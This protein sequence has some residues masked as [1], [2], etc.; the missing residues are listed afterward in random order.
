MAAAA[1]SWW[2][3]VLGLRRL[4][5]C[6]LQRRCGTWEVVQERMQ[7]VVLI[8]DIWKTKHVLGS[9]FVDGKYG[10]LI[11]RLSRGEVPDRKFDGVSGVLL[12]SDSFNDNGF[13]FCEPHW[14]SVKLH[15]I[16]GAASNLGEEVICHSFLRWL[17]WW[18][19]R[20]VTDVGVKLR[21]VGFYVTC[22]LFFMI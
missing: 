19:R 17:L 16:D 15:I 5:R 11:W 7:I 20:Q 8:D 9:W 18:C 14:R 22:T 3:C 2:T 6:L 12:R 21:D 10:F 4:R 1:P 13:T